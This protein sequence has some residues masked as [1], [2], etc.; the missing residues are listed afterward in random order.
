M[1]LG[2][3]YCKSLVLHLYPSLSMCHSYNHFHCGRASH[4][5]ILPPFL[6]RSE[7]QNTCITHF[8]WDTSVSAV[9][10]IGPTFFLGVLPGMPYLESQ[11]GPIVLCSKLSPS[12]H[13]VP[14]LILIFWRYSGFPDTGISFTQ[15]W[16]LTHFN[17]TKSNLVSTLFVVY[18]QNLHC[19]CI[20]SEPFFLMMARE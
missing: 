7:G 20:Y 5:Y 15:Q 1:I 10:H 11:Q 2:F 12:S 9:S 13:R 19:C 17:I 16:W 14:G 18:G 6:F 3:I 8:S 4:Y